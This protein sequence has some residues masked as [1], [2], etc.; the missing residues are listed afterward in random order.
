MAGLV[1]SRG[2]HICATLF[3]TKSEKIK[4]VFFN[5][6]SRDTLTQEPYHLGLFLNILDGQ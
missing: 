2:Q 5:F 1:I 4:K 6:Y 3:N